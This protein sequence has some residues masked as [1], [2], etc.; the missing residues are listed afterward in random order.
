[1]TIASI[2]A[3]LSVLVAQWLAWGAII[4]VRPGFEVLRTPVKADHVIR[5]AL[6][7]IWFIL[8]YSSIEM[9]V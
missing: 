2:Q 5:Y 7:N 9:V 4:L 1:M 3:F 6:N 8:D